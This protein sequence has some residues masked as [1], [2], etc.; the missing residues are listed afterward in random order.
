MTLGELN[1]LDL[2]ADLFDQV[3]TTRAV[4]DEVVTQGLALGAPD[5]LTVRLFW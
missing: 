3:H 5:A 4:Y 1:R 2:L